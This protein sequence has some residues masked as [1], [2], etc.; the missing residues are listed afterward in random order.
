MHFQGVLS[1]FGRKTIGLHADV[2]GKIFNS[3]RNDEILHSTE[4]TIFVAQIIPVFE[5]EEEEEEENNV[6]KERILVD[7]FSPF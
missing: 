5:G 2:F 7:C 1:F 4:S 3:K 6:E